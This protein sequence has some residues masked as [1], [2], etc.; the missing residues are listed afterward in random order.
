MR[1]IENYNLTKNFSFHELIEGK[2][3]PQLAVEMN[4]LFL[5]NSQEIETIK[6]N[7]KQIA[8][9]MQDVRDLINK[10]FPQPTEIGIR[11]FSGF[12]CLEWEYHRNRKGTSQHVQG[13][14]VDFGLTN[15]HDWELYQEIMNFIH[16]YYV[17]HKW[18]GGLA[19]KETNNGISFIHIDCRKPTNEH[20]KRGYGA[21]WNY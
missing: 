11:I 9:E 17:K 10:E 21:R 19:I 2:S 15:V 5:V 3:L 18:M 14:A 12:R 4:W 16:G 1:K 20:I 7:L 8:V 6:S 13:L